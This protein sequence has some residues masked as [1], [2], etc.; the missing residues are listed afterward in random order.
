MTDNE[1]YK[2]SQVEHDQILEELKKDTFYGKL[3]QQNPQAFILGGQP[4][5]GKSLLIG[6][7]INQENNSDFVIINADEFRYAHPQ[8]KEIASQYPKDFASYT[9][10]DV[11]MWGKE[12]FDAARQNRYSLI[13]EG[14]MRTDQICNTIKEMRQEGYQIHI[15][16]MAVPKVQSRISIYAR[17]QDQLDKGM[18]ARFTDTKAHD[19]AYIGMLSTL[20]KIEDEKLY[21]TIQ[22]FNRNGEI[23]FNTGDKNITNAIEKERNKPLS[24]DNQKSLSEDCDILLDKMKKR[25][26]KE[27]YIQDL[28]NLRNQLQHP[29]KTQART[30]NELR[31]LSSSSAKA[32]HVPQSLSKTNTSTLKHIKTKQSNSR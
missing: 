17:Y 30:I 23:L 13:H 25:G 31:G 2:L 18:P 7:C 32:P 22:V 4:G 27:E 14:T 11:R 28:S 24:T 29:N 1:P 26:E 20:Q 19:D 16:V 6:H 8:A 9:D 3:P 15:R 10:P 5:S 21:D 12:I